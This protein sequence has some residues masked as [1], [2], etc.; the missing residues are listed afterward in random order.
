M[1]KEAVDVHCHIIEHP[2]ATLDNTMT[3]LM[4]LMGT[5]PQDWGLVQECYQRFPQR[6]IPCFGS[7]CL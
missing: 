3:G 6:I 1:L 2:I 7:I 4:I 5:C